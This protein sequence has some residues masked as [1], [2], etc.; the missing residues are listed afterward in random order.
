MFKHFIVISEKN[1]IFI[2]N[3]FIKKAARALNTKYFFK[4][5]KEREKSFLLKILLAMVMVYLFSY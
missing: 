3:V 4:S 2:L 5:N 1:R